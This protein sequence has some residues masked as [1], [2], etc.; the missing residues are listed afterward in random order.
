MSL[1]I[2]SLDCLILSCICPRNVVFMCRAPLGR[3]LQICAKPEPMPLQQGL[4]SVL[5]AGLQQ[6]FHSSSF[7]P[8]PEERAVRMSKGGLHGNEMRLSLHISAGQVHR[9]G[10]RLS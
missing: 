2:G 6:H 7:Q 5:A 1:V 4:H 3:Q 10:D 9:C 8:L